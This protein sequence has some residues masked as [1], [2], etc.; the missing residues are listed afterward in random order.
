MTARQNK[1]ARE[2]LTEKNSQDLQ[3]LRQQLLQK[4]QQQKLQSNI[5]KIGG[6]PEQGTAARSGVGLSPVCILNVQIN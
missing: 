5:N 3:S 6:Q 4:A 1:T 2:Q